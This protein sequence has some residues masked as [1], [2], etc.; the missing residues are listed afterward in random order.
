MILAFFLLF[1]DLKRQ[2]QNWLMDLF[3][4]SKDAHLKDDY[5]NLQ[6]LTTDSLLEEL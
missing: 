6:H 4:T 5:K 2:S 3:D 1:W